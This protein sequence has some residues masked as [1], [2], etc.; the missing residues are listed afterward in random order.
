M[1]NRKAPLG[2]GD[3]RHGTVNGYSDHGCRCEL[4]SAEKS[5]KSRAYYVENADKKRR[6]YIE[7]LDRIKKQRRAYYV[8]N[9]AKV[10]GANR[11]WQLEHKEEA[12][13]IVAANGV[14]NRARWATDDPYADPSTKRCSD[15]R[16]NLPRTAF[17]ITK[18]ARNGLAPYCRSCW[19]ARVQTRKAKKFR[20]WVEDVDRDVL[21]QRDCGVCYICGL[22]ADPNDWHLEHKI[23]IKLGGEHSY[24]NTGVSHPIC[25]L[26]KGSSLISA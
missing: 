7:N 25:N 1:A 3:P 15:C 23:P 13:A 24:A 22:P 20:Q 26:R 18:A 19:S 21:W 9:S 14:T 5:A 8:E 2:I 11:L 4:C 12:L 10:L 17:H 6:Y 16:V